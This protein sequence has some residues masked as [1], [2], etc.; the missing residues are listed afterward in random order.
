MLN[1]IISIGYETSGIDSGN[2]S[3]I[4][5]VHKFESLQLSGLKDLSWILSTLQKKVIEQI[6]K[7][8]KKGG[9]K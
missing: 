9:Q 3:Y 4:I 2:L 6:N 1:P 7:K 5:L 8:S